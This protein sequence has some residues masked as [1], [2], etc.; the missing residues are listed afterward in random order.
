MGRIQLDGRRT[1]YSRFGD[2]F[3]YVCLGLVGVW[4]LVVVQGLG[5]LG[6][7]AEVWGWRDL[8]RGRGRPGSRSSLAYLAVF[9]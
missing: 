4:V 7:A 8:A 3:V 2:V 9:A 5:L 6:G 1:V